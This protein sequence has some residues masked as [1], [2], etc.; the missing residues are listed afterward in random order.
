[1]F[2]EMVNTIPR[3]SINS[4]RRKLEYTR[5]AKEE[6]LKE[7]IGNHRKTRYQGRMCGSSDES[8]FKL[9]SLV[10]ISEGT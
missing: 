4:K 5:E 10:N 7:N 1:M 8:S 2:R 6:R 3:F 9:R